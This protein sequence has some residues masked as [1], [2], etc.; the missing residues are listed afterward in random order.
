VHGSGV[1]DVP[2]RPLATLTAGQAVSGPVLI[3][4]P[5]TTIV[6]ADVSTVELGPAGSVLITPVREAGAQEAA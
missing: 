4:S 6:V 2:V 5:F 1:I 3:E